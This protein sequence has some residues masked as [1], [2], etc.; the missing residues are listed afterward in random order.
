VD[1]LM[2][3]FSELDDEQLVRLHDEFV[4]RDEALW[5]VAMKLQRKNKA[6]GAAYQL[7]VKSSSF[8]AAS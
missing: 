3:S 4:A 8:G 1:E 7:A 5:K 6:S 2:D